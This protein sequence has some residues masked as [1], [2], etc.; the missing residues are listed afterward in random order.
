[1]PARKRKRIRN[2][3]REVRK[4]KTVLKAV[5]IL[6]AILFAVVYYKISGKFWRDDRKT[7][8]VINQEGGGV[9]V[10]VFDP[11]LNE[12]TT[13]SIP[14]ETEV[15]VAQQKGKWKLKSVWKLGENEEL[16]GVLLAETISK[17]FKFPV[18]AWADKEATVIVDTKVSEIAIFLFSPFKTNLSFIDRL[19]LIVFSLNIDNTHK[20]HIELSKTGYLKRKVLA[21]GTHGF[22]KNG[23]IPSS[24]AVIFQE[25]EIS[26][27]NLKVVIIDSSRRTG[28]AEEIGELVEALGAKVTAVVKK[29]LPDMDCTVFSENK[30]Y[31]EIFSQALY[32]EN[33]NSEIESGVDVEILIGEK[34]L[35]RY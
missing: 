26:E 7:S 34:Y 16:G 2:T 32:C 1:M 20:I 3:S 10:A 15:T 12:I 23:K 35:K 6:L 19:K 11:Y 33:T 8:M 14:A 18:V 22:G 25:P 29:D 13:I 28:F 5:I 24:L 21:D 4:K 30:K 31:R 17:Y 9:L 27:S